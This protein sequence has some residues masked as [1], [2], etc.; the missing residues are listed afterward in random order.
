M[1]RYGREGCNHVWRYREGGWEEQCAP[2]ICIECGAFSC[3]CDYFNKL[4]SR[5]SPEDYEKAKRI[6]FDE[7]VRYDAN[8]NGKWINPYVEGD[9]K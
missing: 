7:S 4:P 9:I 5:T 6:F 3:G 8:V 2:A 1:I